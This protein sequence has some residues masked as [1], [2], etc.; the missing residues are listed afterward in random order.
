MAWGAA[1]WGGLAGW[2]LVCGTGLQCLVPL[3]TTDAGTCL[4]CGAGYHGWFGVIR[5][6]AVL[7]FVLLGVFLEVTRRALSLSSKE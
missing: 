1:G 2:W 5:G 4:G 6:F 7:G 3:V